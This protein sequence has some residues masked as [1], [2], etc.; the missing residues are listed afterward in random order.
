MDKRP[1]IV[2]SLAMKDQFQAKF[3]ASIKSLRHGRR[4]PF[5][6][7]VFKTLMGAM[8]ESEMTAAMQAISFGESDTLSQLLINALQRLETGKQFQAGLPQKESSRQ[9]EPE[10]R[11]PLRKP[12]ITSLVE[13]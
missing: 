11:E 4:N 5:F 6:F 9:E 1:T 12:N 3:E 8:D 2:I 7:N 13:D 10:Y